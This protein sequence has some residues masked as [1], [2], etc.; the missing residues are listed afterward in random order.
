MGFCASHS[1]DTSAGHTVLL[2]GVLCFTVFVA[3][4]WGGSTE[5]QPI[6]P[7][8]APVLYIASDPAGSGLVVATTSSGVF[9]SQDDGQSWRYSG[10]FG[11]APRVAVVSPTDAAR[12]YVGTEHDS[13][14]RSLD[15]GIT[16]LSPTSTDPR[17]ATVYTVAA[18]PDNADIVLAGGTGLFRSLDGGAHWSHLAFDAGVAGIAFDPTDASTIF[19]SVGSLQGQQGGIF[20]STDGGAT[21][22][23]IREGT[24]RYWSDGS[25]YYPLVLEF[26]V[27]ARDAQTIYARTD[28]E[29]FKSID[30][31]DHWQVVPVLPEA[32][33][34][35]YLQGVV[36][37]SND[38][39][40]VY[41]ATLHHGVWKSSDG[42]QLW[43]PAR[44]GLE[45]GNCFSDGTGCS[46]EDAYYS[47][48]NA[49]A[50]ASDGQLVAGTSYLGAFTSSDGGASWHGANSGLDA[51]TVQAIAVAPGS[52]TALASIADAGMVVSRDAGRTW[53]LANPG[54]ADP[55]GPNRFGPSGFALDC[56][57]FDS[58]ASSPDL[59]AVYI[60]GP[61]GAFT[62]Q[63]RGAT[64][65]TWSI[66]YTGEVAA[67]AS[68]TSGAAS[69]RIAVDPLDPRVVYGGRCRSS[70]AGASWP[71]CGQLPEGRPAVAQAVDP[72]VQ[73]TLYAGT[74]DG[75]VVVSHDS[76]AS[77]G[78]ITLDLETACGDRP[79]EVRAIVPDRR[80]Q[81]TVYAAASCGIF[82]SRD[83]AATWTLSGL[84]G[85]DVRRL[86]VDS[87]QPGILYA[88]TADPGVQ[89]SRDGGATWAQLGTGLEGL[90]VSA[91]ALDPVTY[92][93]FA[94][95]AMLPS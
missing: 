17:L 33:D 5:W 49:L 83:G 57:D 54:I 4:A 95:S 14:L 60:V 36:V 56:L 46:L 76:C 47:P 6:G 91:L 66:C 12:M 1:A 11:L 89:W 72:F 42:G 65:S 23:P 79:G 37:G 22:V 7:G 82:V 38:C 84:Y 59:A 61:C 93:L 25:S 70:D 50:V 8:G 15:G 31:G 21:W 92:T 13:V 41:V 39:S 81:G 51:T 52:T 69:T 80:R 73:T 94:G 74:D 63:D 16:W 3:F 19:V 9:V 48:L 77:W 18:A 87:R 24:L 35:R 32:T 40:T 28:R 44:S 30:A 88:A 78:G 2:L 90:T 85:T 64:W 29:L 62:S 43:S 53:G 58:L 86:V 55:C 68:A 71:V 34:S 27:C 45:C 67:E 10:L 20:R 26:A 75:K